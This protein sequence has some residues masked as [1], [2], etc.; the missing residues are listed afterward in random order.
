MAILVNHRI[1]KEGYGNT[2]LQQV[3]QIYKSD[4]CLLVIVI[5]SENSLVNFRNKLNWCPLENSSIYRRNF[6]HLDIQVFYTVLRVERFTVNFLA[7]YHII[8]YSNSLYS[9]W[10]KFQILNCSLIFT[11]PHME[12]G[13]LKMSSIKKKLCPYLSLKP[14][15]SNSHIIKKNS[16]IP[17][18]L[19]KGETLVTQSESTTLF[20]TWSLLISPSFNSMSGISFPGS[21]AF[22]LKY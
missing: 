11:V 4:N 10:P 22:Y 1:K 14:K 3:S 2:N 15:D 20:F 19:G 17:G 8:W 21:T 16:T 6:I 12:S 18:L 7:W 5:W 9:I 13:D